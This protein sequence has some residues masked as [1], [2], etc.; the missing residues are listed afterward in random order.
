MKQTQNKWRYWLY[1]K[2]MISHNYNY[3]MFKVKEKT[4]E[5]Y[6]LKQNIF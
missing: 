4:V 5:T 6:I 1:H 3:H 2:Q